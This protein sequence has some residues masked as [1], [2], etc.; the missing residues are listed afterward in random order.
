MVKTL[1]TTTR[2]TFPDLLPA[3]VALQAALSDP[4]ATLYPVEPFNT[5]VYVVE[6]TNALGV[7]AITAI[8]T[9]LNALA[10]YTDERIAQ[11][12]IDNWPITLKA[13]ALTLVDQI[14]VLRQA[15]PVPLP[16]VSVAQALL[17]IRTKAGL[18]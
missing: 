14:N 16:T 10:A 12:Q 4:A 13:L 2:T 1:I 6:T 17:A 11:D 9:Q 8:T 5:A 18:L 7:N 15:L 3:R